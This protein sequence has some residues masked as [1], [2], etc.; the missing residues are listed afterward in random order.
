MTFFSR[1]KELLFN[2]THLILEE[3]YF[4]EFLHDPYGKWEYPNISGSMSQ[5]SLENQATETCGIP[6][7]TDSLI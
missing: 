6:D 1:K 2:T 4:E 7:S 3:N 5:I